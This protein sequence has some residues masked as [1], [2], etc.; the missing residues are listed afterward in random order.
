[1]S[2]RLQIR[3][4]IKRISRNIAQQIVHE[5]EGPGL[6]G[7]YQ[8][9]YKF[10]VM[11]ILVRLVSGKTSIE[12]LKSANNDLT[13]RL[14]SGMLSSAQGNFTNISDLL[15]NLTDEINKNDP[16]SRQNSPIPSIDDI[17][18][19]PVSDIQKDLDN[20]EQFGT[21]IFSVEDENFLKNVG[22]RKRKRKTRRRRRKKRKGKKHT[23]RKSRKKRKRS[24]RRKRKR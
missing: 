16:N 2:E 17:L 23:R 3:E 9:I 8:N 24:R 12:E 1:M 13:K 20:N 15:E 7:Q 10:A 4:I 22:G 19:S 11:T 6:I 21:P 18:N 5:H 14:K